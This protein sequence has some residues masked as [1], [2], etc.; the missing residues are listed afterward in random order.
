MTRQW[1][2]ASRLIL[3]DDDGDLNLSDLHLSFKITKGGQETPNTCSITVYNVSESTYARTRKEYTRVILQAGY[4]EALSTLFE[5]NITEAKQTPSG[6]TDTLLVLQAADGDQAYNHAAVNHTLAAGASEEQATGVLGRSLVDQG[7]QAPAP[8]RSQGGARTLRGQ[9]LY[10]PSRLSL[11][12]LARDQEASWSMQNGALQ[13]VGDE[14]NLPGTAIILS[15]TT[16]L[17]GSPRPSD[18]GYSLSCLLNPAFR[19]DGIIELPEIGQCRLLSVEHSGDTRGND[20]SSAL[21]CL[22]LSA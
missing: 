18:E 16:G 14:G 17:L 1:L 12:V 4:T 6:A 21:V 20:W 22:P 7:S 11:R 10:A 15:P 2:R 19:V 5:G 9:A 8:G 3:Q 13:N